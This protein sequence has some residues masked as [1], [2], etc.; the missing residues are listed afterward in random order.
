[1]TYIERPNI[2]AIIPIYG[3]VGTIGKVLSKFEDHVVDRICVV[4]DCPTDQSLQEIDIARKGMDIPVHIIKNQQ[5]MGIGYAIRAGLEFALN[6]GFDIIVV[7]AGNDKDDPREIPQ[8]VRPILKVGY[9]YVQGSR[10][11]RGGRAVKNPILRGLFSR[12]YPLIWTLITGFWC[13]DVTNG[14]R[15]YRVGILRS[16]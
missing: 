15:A 12:I 9:D 13:T 4:V 7:M 8:L 3:Q 5:R 2:V 6:G 1:M 16:P 11:L 10:F 14:F